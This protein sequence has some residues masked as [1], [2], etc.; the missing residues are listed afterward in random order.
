M[1]FSFIQAFPNKAGE[2]HTHPNTKAEIPA[3]ATASQLTVSMF[4]LI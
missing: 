4:G 3:T 1:L 2:Y